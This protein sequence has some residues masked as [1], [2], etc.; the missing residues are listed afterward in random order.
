M[1][2]EPKLIQTLSGQQQ[3]FK[4]EI[5]ASYSNDPGLIK[6]WLNTEQ[7]WAKTEKLSNCWKAEKSARAKTK[8]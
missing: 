6:H 3:W 2:T 1:L 5:Q 4:L 7:N 8:T